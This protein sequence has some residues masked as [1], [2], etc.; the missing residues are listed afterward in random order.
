VFF[1]IHQFHWWLLKLNPF[2]ISNSNSTQGAKE[3]NK[4]FKKACI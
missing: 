2:G 3:M 1:M 4:S